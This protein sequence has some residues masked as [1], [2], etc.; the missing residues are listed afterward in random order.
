MG[1][2]IGRNGSGT[3]V[4]AGRLFRGRTAVVGFVL[5]IVVAQ[6]CYLA[7]RDLVLAFDALTLFSPYFTLVADYAR[8]GQLLLWNPLTNCGSPDMAYV[9][10]GSFSP[11]TVL[12]A[13]ATAGGDT[14]FLLYMALIWGLAGTGMGFLG[15]HLRAPIW[16]VLAATV[17]FLLGGF[18]LGH[19]THTSDRK[20][21]V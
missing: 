12:T 3:N 16:A 9:E 18:S 7:L 21:V 15:L 8:A 1:A 11:L 20:S 13:W 19:A 10:M 4:R 2:E 17:S 14:G 6:V 5:L